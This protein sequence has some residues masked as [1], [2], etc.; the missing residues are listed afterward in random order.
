VKV[1]TKQQKQ[2]RGIMKKQRL[3]LEYELHSNSA[4]IIWSLIS[5]AH[6]LEKW[7]ADSVKRQ[8]DSFIFRWGEEWGNHEIRKAYILSENK[9]ESIR[10]R[11]D[12][13]E[14]KDAYWQLGMV[15]SDITNDYIL[16][17]TDFAEADDM[18]SLRDI[19][20]SNMEQLHRST[21]L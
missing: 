3:N 15:K 14:D 8:D 16:T 1:L 21:G 5:S 7:I 9:Q 19:W 12:N 6:G 17:V 10:L 2:K 20:D 11:W 4:N 13:D 18:E